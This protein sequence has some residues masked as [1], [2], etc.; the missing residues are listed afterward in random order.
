VVLEGDRLRLQVGHAGATLNEVEIRGMTEL[1]PGD[2]L[3]EGEFVYVVL[4][5]SP[6]V[7][8]R[9]P[10]LLEHW[11]WQ[12]RL[13]EEVTAADGTFTI[14]LG[15]SGA[16]A[17]EFAPQALAEYLASNELRVVLGSFG[18]NLIEM[19]VIGE[20][21]KAEALRQFISD[22]AAGQDETVRWGLASFP[23]HAA[24]SEELWSVALNR[25][26]GLAASGPQ[27]MVW[28]DPCMTRLRSLADRWAASTALAFV[29][30]EGV[31]RESF[32]RLVRASRTPAAPFV[33]HPTARFDRVRWN[34][35]VA[36][37]GGGSLHVRRPEMM[38]EE[39]RRAFW[40]ASSFQPSAAFLP[41]GAQDSLPRSQVVLPDLI[42]RPADVLPIA[43]L[44]L[45]LVDAQLGRRRSSLRAETR[46]IVQGLSGPENVRTLRNV[47]ACGA[48]N[49]VGAEVRPEHLQIA[50]AAP[51]ASGVRAKI[52]EMERREIEA[53]LHGS[54]WNVAE[55]ARRMEL[56]RRTLVYRMARLGLRRP[57]G[58]A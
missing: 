26:L 30:A 22:R 57:R 37:A 28:N 55:A 40:G 36:R 27:E 51:V 53:A 45:H 18:R 7:A 46:A 17:P 31:G 29:G 56:P 24:T 9:L 42:D 19:L 38:P 44:V 16:F 1:H 50:S 11:S 21:G 6:A 49:A 33:V 34:E 47:V 14:L 10:M 48:L 25:L 58:S 43:E 5:R 35:D 4:P 39:I 54:G 15:R 32:A 12:Q 23:A 2:L 8:S 20:P 41:S 13:E 52:R 3:S